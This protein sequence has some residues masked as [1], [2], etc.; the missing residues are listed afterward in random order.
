MRAFW[1]AIVACF[2]AAA[3]V[4]PV[5]AETLRASTSAGD[6]FSVL[7]T[8]STS[9]SIVK[10]STDAQRYLATDRSTRQRARIDD[11]AGSAPAVVA[12]P[13]VAE[14]ERTVVDIAS[15]SPWC[16][17]VRVELG[18]CSARGPPVA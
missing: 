17:L 12:I 8:A 3:G 4:R 9:P 15:R 10:R 5:D 16:D 11:G 1:T 7:Y 18:T 14:P 2:I 6:A 13:L